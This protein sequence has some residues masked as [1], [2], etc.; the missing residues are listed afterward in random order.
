MRILCTADIHIGRRSSFDAELDGDFSTLSAWLR[1]AEIAIQQKADAVVIA[2]DFFENLE[3]QYETR[4]KV[5]ASLEKLKDVNIP[6]LAVAGNHD[7]SALRVFAN[8]HPTLIHVFPSDKWDEVAIG[9]VRFLGRSFAK[10]TEPISMLDNLERRFRY[11]TTIGIVHADIDANSSYGP[12][13]LPDFSGRGVVAWVV[14]HVHAPR[15][16]R[17]DPLVTYPGSPQAMDWGETGP[18]GFQWLEVEGGRANLS[19]VIPVS[20][21]RYEVVTITLAEEETLDEAVSN[22]AGEIRKNQPDLESVHFRI[23]LRF[24]ADSKPIFPS[25]ATFLGPD[26]YSVLSATPVP[27]IDLEAQCQQPDAAGQ[28]ARLLLGLDGKGSAKWQQDVNA[29]VEG[30][31]HDM[32]KEWTKIH[33]PDTEEY[34]LLTRFTPDEAKQTVRRTLENII[35]QQLETSL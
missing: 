5:K 9:D 33:L 17:G 1:I 8:A 16:F 29:I 11:E 22:L 13:P 12:T 23:H 27:K 2:G 14:G 6:V 26:V 10:E 35:S 20:T 34:L 7:S 31:V 21:V 19:E 32:R 28:A 30:V 4:P 18:R 3:A 24:S 15:L 25:T